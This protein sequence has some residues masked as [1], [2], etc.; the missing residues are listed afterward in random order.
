MKGTPSAVISAVICRY[1]ATKRNQSERH[2]ITNVPCHVAS[3]L[4][5]AE[6]GGAGEA[7]FG[8]APKRSFG[9]SRK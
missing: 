9:G 1:D 4:M 2:Y 5:A 7:V 3:G 8:D 6:C